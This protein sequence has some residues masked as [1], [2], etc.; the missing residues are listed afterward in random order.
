MTDIRRNHADNSRRAI[1]ALAW[2]I[3][4][5]NIAA[6]LLALTDTAIIGRIGSTADLGGLALGSLLFNLLYWTFGFLRMGTTGFVANAN[7]RDDSAAV[8]AHMLRAGL[9]ALVC[10]SAL[11]ALQVPLLAA[12][13]A[14]FDASAAVES[15]ASE[16][17]SIRLWSAPASLMIVAIMGGLIG[18]G[19][20][21]SVLIVQLV[22]N[23]LNIAL[24]L[25]LGVGLGLGIVGVAIGTVIAEWL[26]AGLALVLLHRVL[27][28]RASDDEPMLPFD[29][30]RN[31]AG[32][33][34]VLSANGDIMLRTLCLLLGF[35]WFTNRGA[36]FGDVV[37][38]ANHLLLQFITFSAFFLDGFANAAESRVGAALGARRVER[39]DRVVRNSTQLAVATAAAL[40]A[41]VLLFG[42]LL[43][44]LLTDLP[45]VRT[46]ATDYLPWT[47]LYVL[48]SVGA[49]QLDGVF[50]GASQTRAMRNASVVAVLIFLAL[51]LLFGS[52][53]NLGLWL[54]F[55]GYVIARACTLVAAYP[56]LRRRA[57]A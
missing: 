1:L 29:R 31:W 26:A 45:D 7:G 6:P 38:A 16:Y 20:S 11:T 23:G 30:L 39:L 13:L 14:A 27:K 57:M 35:A 2:P 53:Q 28:A 5:A 55:V 41:T 33:R 51:S 10:G 21:R 54:A 9:L 34:A 47:A 4:L 56:A 42:P 49:F 50:I 8:R 22:L 3:V 40:A 43:I 15:V 44:N 48:L 25:W 19:D 12:G 46:V 18:L 36:Q 32:W 37:L 17:L 24:D 52:W